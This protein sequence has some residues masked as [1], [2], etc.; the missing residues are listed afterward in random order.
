MRLQTS[1][2]LHR[3]R[4][5]RLDETIASHLDQSLR[6]RPLARRQNVLIVS[7]LSGFLMNIGGR[8]TSFA[9]SDRSYARSRSAPSP[10][11]SFRNKR[12]WYQHELQYHRR[13]WVCRIPSCGVIFRHSQNFISHLKTDHSKVSDDL[14]LDQCER[15]TTILEDQCPF[16]SVAIPMDRMRTHVGNHLIDCALSALPRAALDSDDPFLK[17]AQPSNTNDKGGSEDQ[18]TFLRGLGLGSLQ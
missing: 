18:D 12:K 11:G 10:I 8:S 3:M 9:I 16:C 4:Q 6:T 15:E 14:V 1:C 2:P 5:M 13:E 17:V 7:R